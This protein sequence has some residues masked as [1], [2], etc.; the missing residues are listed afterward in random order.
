MYEGYR[1]LSG[2][3]GHLGQSGKVKVSKGRKRKNKEKK[4]ENT[5]T[6]IKTVVE[7]KTL[8]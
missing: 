5:S 6:R 4:V 8:E 7:E 3:R 2:E 1:R